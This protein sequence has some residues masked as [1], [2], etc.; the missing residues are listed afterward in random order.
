[1]HGCMVMCLCRL[2]TFVPSHRVQRN[3]YPLKASDEIQSRVM[4]KPMRTVPVPSIFS[5]IR[6]H[7]ELTDSNIS[8]KSCRVSESGQ[9]EFCGEMG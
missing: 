5:P 1:M 8:M 2:A 9:R 4:R 7:L 3:I 6:L